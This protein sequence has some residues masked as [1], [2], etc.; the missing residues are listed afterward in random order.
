MFNLIYFVATPEPSA[1]PTS[2][3]SYSSSN[4]NQAINNS[5]AIEQ[6]ASIIIA[7]NTINSTLLLPLGGTC[8]FNEECTSCR[9][10]LVL[11]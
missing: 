3:P 4:A 6:V 9:A 5:T 8:Q 10:E 11:G 7:L 1:A 2:F